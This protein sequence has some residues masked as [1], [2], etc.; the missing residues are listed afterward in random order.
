M[1]KDATLG[2]NLVDKLLPMVARLRTTLYPAFGVRQYQVY[3][4]RRAWSGTQRGEGTVTV[5]S[6]EEMTPRPLVTP[7]GG[8]ASMVPGGLDEADN[9]MLTEVDLRYTEQELTGRPLLENEEWLYR[10]DDGHGQEIRSRWFELNGT[11]RTDRERDIG[12]AIPLHEVEV[13]G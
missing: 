3:L 11:P 1:A 12:W 6:T 2:T 13:K 9:V 5:V 8:G 10:I 4:V 7:A